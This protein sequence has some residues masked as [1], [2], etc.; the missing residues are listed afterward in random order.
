[1]CIYWSIVV[2]GVRYCSPESTMLLRAT[3]SVVERVTDNDEVE[4]SIP[5]SPMGSLIIIG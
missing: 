2:Q 1:M 4:G 3:S 5:S